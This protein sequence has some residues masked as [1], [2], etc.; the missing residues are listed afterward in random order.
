MVRSPVAMLASLAP[1]LV[2]PER[3]ARDD[4]RAQ[5]GR[6][7]RELAELAA[8]TYPRIDVSRCR[9][10]GGA[11]GPRIL[12]LGDLE[13]TRDE[14]FD[15]LSTLRGHAAA[16]A[17]RQ[18]QTRERLERMLA[19]PP[20]HRNLRIANADL[21]LPGCTTYESRPR[22][23]LIGMLAGW[24]HVKISSGCPLPWGP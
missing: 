15:R 17:T 2:A 24:W 11:G 13:R 21:G 22:L 9:R 6:L 19:D 3:A 8:A 16:Q 7:D 4:L 12:G 20:G 14:L 5:I 18:A 10:R 23:G 1:P